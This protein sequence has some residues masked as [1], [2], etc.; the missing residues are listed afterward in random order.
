[1][2][3]I[4]SAKINVLPVLAFFF[5]GMIAQVHLQPSCIFQQE[6]NDGSAAGG[7][8][9]GNSHNQLYYAPADISP[10]NYG[11]RRS[12]FQNGTITI[13]AES[14]KLIRCVFE[15]IKGTSGLLLKNSLWYSSL[16]CEIILPP[17]WSPSIPISYRRLII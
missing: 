1:M 12:A 9:V 2:R 15:S 8:S 3:T 13:E 4:P 7:S 11:E 14:L 16:T 6:R 5:V 10:S 17:G